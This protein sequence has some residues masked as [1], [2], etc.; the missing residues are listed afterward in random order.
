LWPPLLKHLH[1]MATDEATGAGHDDEII[2]RH[3]LKPLTFFGS[4]GRSFARSECQRQPTGADLSRTI[5]QV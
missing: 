1:Q 3:I 5:L 2:L 4:P